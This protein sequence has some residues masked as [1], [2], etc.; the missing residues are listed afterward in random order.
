MFETH[1]NPAN[2]LNQEQGA[3]MSKL[4]HVACCMV[5]HMLCCVGGRVVHGSP[6]RWQTQQPKQQTNHRGWNIHFEVLSS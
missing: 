2:S 6:C 5:P 4:I 3:E 1:P